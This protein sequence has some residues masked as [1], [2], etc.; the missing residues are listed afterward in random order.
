VEEERQIHRPPRSQVETDEG[1]DH[2]KGGDA[3]LGELEKIGQALA[4]AGAGQRLDGIVGTVH[5]ADLAARAAADTSLSP[6]PTREPPAGKTIMT[7]RARAARTVRIRQEAR[8]RAPTTTCA[9]AGST[10]RRVRTVAA[11][12]RIWTMTSPARRSAGRTSS[13]RS[14]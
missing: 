5:E 6:S 8:R 9:V 11:P 3:R 1:R 4:G 7:G 2:D 13:R 14:A 10:A 12:S